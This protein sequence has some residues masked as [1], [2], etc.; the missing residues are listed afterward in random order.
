MH[1][2][3]TGAAGFIGQ[4][5]ASRLSARGDTVTG[6]DIVPMNAHS[7]PGT[8]V[9]GDVRDKRAIQKA[10]VG[11]ETVFHLAAAHHD[12]GIDESTYRGVNV[13]GTKLLC[14]VMSECEI[15][16]LCFYSS[17]AAF[18]DTPEPRTEDAAA[19]PASAYGQSKLDAEQVIHSWWSNAQGRRALIIRPTLTF[20]PMN[21]GNMYSLIN[22]IYRGLYLQ[23]GKGE[24]I[25]S[26]C[27]VE[28][29]LDATLFLWDSQSLAEFDCFNYVDKPDL[30]S[31][32]LS[33]LI[34]AAL[35]RKRAGM[36]VPLG[37]ALVMCWPF[38]LV[39][40]VFGLN[41]KISTARVRKFAVERTV[42]DAAKVRAAGF[43]PKMELAE[44]ISVTVKWFLEEG[45]KTKPVSRPAPKEIYL[46]A[47]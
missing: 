24:N 22:Q 21:F 42:F 23:V 18:G 26:I 36:T 3:I 31:R 12:F 9:R 13:E 45:R 2:L 39:N 8:F 30:C 43:S 37:L 17:V 40:K 5:L 6:L 46:P 19:R 27:Y 38:D 44:A 7:F 41:T 16:Q 32:R 1:A 25:K 15:R 11:C 14:D 10:I 4:K 20:G 28:N 35:G 33:E 29:L 34:G 47:G